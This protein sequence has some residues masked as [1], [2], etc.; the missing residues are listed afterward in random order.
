MSSLSPFQLM[1]TVSP[2]YQAAVAPASKPGDRPINKPEGM[3]KPYLTFQ[4]LTDVP[5][6]DVLVVLAHP[7]DEILLSG[8]VAQLAQTGKSVQMLYATNGSAGQ[9]VSG[10][11]EADDRLGETRSEEVVRASR[12]L[13]V[14]RPP[15]ILDFMDGKTDAFPDALKAQLRAVLLQV[16]PETLLMYNAQD[17]LTGHA[18][19]K[20]IARYLQ[21]ELDAISAGNTPQDQQARLKIAR[22]LQND[23]IYQAILPQSA[24]SSFRYFFPATDPSWKDVRFQPDANAAFRV[25]LPRD[26]QVRKAESMRQHVSQY[27][28]DDVQKMSGFVA[29]YPYETFTRY[30]IQTRHQMPRFTPTQFALRNQA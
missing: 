12:L 13:N 28:N 24:A 17:G 25:F 10:R 29:A 26:T 2:F 1:P 23:G 14:Q 8:A 15:I 16:Q 9:D 7:D 27:R 19:H 4:D 6:A 21:E 3:R 18:D 5:P 30:Q 22:L 11:R 20:N